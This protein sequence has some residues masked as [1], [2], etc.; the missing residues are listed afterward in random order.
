[1]YFL[2]RLTSPQACSY[3]AVGSGIWRSP[4]GHAAMGGPAA[5]PAAMREGGRGQGWPPASGAGVGCWAIARAAE[6]GLGSRG[7]TFSVARQGLS[8]AT[9]QQG[10]AE[11]AGSNG[12]IDDEGR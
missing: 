6:R 11:A 2:L 9:Q 3:A 5:S 7:G 1:M 4:H 12:K 8:T 10:V